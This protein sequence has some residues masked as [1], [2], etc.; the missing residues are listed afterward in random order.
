MN[1]L[2]IPCAFVEHRGFFAWLAFGAYYIYIIIL[3]SCSC[4]IQSFPK[5]DN[6]KC[7]MTYTDILFS[8]KQVFFIY[9]IRYSLLITYGLFDFKRVCSRRHLEVGERGDIAWV[10][11]FLHLQKCFLQTYE[12][13]FFS[14]TFHLIKMFQTFKTFVKSE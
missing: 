2:I 7:E 13:C 8:Q 6:D 11:H 9:G 4:K 10:E 14:T 1:G 5:H 3:I 12:T